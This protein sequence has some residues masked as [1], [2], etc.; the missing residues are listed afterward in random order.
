MSRKKP[1]YP[2]IK[3]EVCGIGFKP[4]STLQRFCPACGKEQDRLRK[5]KSSDEPL[6]RLPMESSPR[7]CQEMLIQRIAHN[8][9]KRRGA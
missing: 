3:C 9:S 5:Q 1:D 7:L 8:I 2:K 4:A 6:S